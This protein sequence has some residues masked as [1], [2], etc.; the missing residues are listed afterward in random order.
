MH[1]LVQLGHGLQTEGGGR[2]RVRKR[3]ELS[4]LWR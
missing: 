4:L 2:V 1:R 3:H